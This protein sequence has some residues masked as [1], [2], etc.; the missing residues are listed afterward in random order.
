M[1]FYIV[2][3]LALVVVV[4]LSVWLAMQ[5]SGYEMRAD[6]RPGCSIFQVKPV[7]YLCPKATRAAP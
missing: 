7:L 2:S 6:W 5:P 1:R 4:A 3:A